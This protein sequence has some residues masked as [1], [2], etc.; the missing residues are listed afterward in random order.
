MNLIFHLMKN[1]LWKFSRFHPSTTQFK[2][3][4]KIKTT[5]KK[6]ENKKA[7]K[8]IFISNR[9]KSFLG[10]SIKFCPTYSTYEAVYWLGF[11]TT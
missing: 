6:S 7:Q 11:S 1:D 3:E 5:E 4:W 9:F 10:E 8:L 2:L